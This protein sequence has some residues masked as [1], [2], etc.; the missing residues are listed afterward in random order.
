MDTMYLHHVDW[1]EN[2][3]VSLY[4][5]ILDGQNFSILILFIHYFTKVLHSL[6]YKADVEVR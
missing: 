2:L 6:S 1:S 4:L 5:K 3:Q